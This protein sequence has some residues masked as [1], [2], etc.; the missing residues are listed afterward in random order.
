[1]NSKWRNNALDSKTLEYG[2]YDRETPIPAESD[3]QLYNNSLQSGHRHTPFA[4]ATQACDVLAENLTPDKKIIAYNQE[5]KLCKA[6][7]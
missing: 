7:R 1:M 3:R 5:N 6:C 4:P 2:G